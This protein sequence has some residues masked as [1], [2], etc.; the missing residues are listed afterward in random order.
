MTVAI[1]TSVIGDLFGTLFETQAEVLGRA[2]HKYCV[3]NRLV[4]LAMNK[5]QVTE[6]TPRQRLTLAR[7]KSPLQQSLAVAM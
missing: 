4:E 6:V 3:Q 1:A 2:L 7:T 5:P